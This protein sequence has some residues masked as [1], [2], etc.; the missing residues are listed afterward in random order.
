MLYD[1]SEAWNGFGC[2]SGKIVG[3]GELNNDRKF[4]RKFEKD[5][6]FIS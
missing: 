3:K 6:V 4:W 5:V 1:I 2:C